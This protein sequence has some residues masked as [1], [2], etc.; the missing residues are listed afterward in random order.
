MREG[1]AE[2]DS[3]ASDV[4]CCVGLSGIIPLFVRGL[5]VIAAVWGKVA[6]YIDLMNVRVAPEHPG[7]V[8]ITHGCDHASVVWIHDA[9]RAAGLI[10]R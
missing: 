6:D 7:S 8:G 2:E 10:M 9:L 1:E 4:S 5:R 3:K